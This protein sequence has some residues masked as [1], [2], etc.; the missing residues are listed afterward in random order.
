VNTSSSPT[1]DTE[2]P[3]FF[4]AS[5]DF[6]SGILTEPS[7]SPLGIAVVLLNGGNH[8]PSTGRNQLGARQCR[9][10]AAEGFHALRFD[11]HGVGD[12]TGDVYQFRLDTPFREDA[13]AAISFLRSRGLDRF[14]LVG[15]C[16]GARTALACAPAVPGLVAIV[17]RTLPVREQEKTELG[18]TDL[19]PKR[20]LGQLAL[21]ALRPRVAAGFFRRSRR[22]VYLRTARNAL[23]ARVQRSR[24]ETEGGVP[25]WMSAQVV[26]EMQ[27]LLDLKVPVL[28]VSGRG[29]PDFAYFEQALT[30]CF[31][32]M[33]AA[34]DSLV[35]VQILDGRVGSGADVSVQQ[36]VI[37]LT[38][39]W[40]ADLHSGRP[41][42]EAIHA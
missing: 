28:L 36:P 31:D 1:S 33:F 3:V 26:S 24:H 4:Q 32:E 39:T 6:L 20:S 9:R 19:M 5:D 2:T 22:R 13:L 21:R 40:L 41:V 18:P 35:D 10:L 25:A 42:G 12:S 37:D 29:D 23:R 8:G 11:Y 17:L 38:A 15:G 27:D 34:A 7:I 16:F 14:V 30:G